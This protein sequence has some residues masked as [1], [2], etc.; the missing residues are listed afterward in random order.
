MKVDH[1]KAKKS[2]T[3]G[4]CHLFGEE[5]REFFN[6]VGEKLID[7][8]KEN[9]RKQ[10]GKEAEMRLL[11]SRYRTIIKFFNPTSLYE[12]VEDFK[13]SLKKELS[14]FFDENLIDKSFD[15]D[16]YRSFNRISL[17]F[18]FDTIKDLQNEILFTLNDKVPNIPRQAL[19]T[20]FK[21][22][23]LYT[24]SQKVTLYSESG[25]CLDQY[26]A[27]DVKYYIEENEDFYL[28]ESI[29][30]KYHALGGVLIRE[31]LRENFVSKIKEFITKDSNYFT[32]WT[33]T[34][35]LNVYCFDSEYDKNLIEI[36]NFLN[37]ENSF[38]TSKQISRSLKNLRPSDLPTELNME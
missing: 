11:N 37:D 16:D 1:I 6:D 8:G 33:L 5:F 24:N 25:L 36:Q 14:L 18:P 7:L 34:D 20:Y 26:N 29:P 4:F 23:K 22:F 32:K 3:D 28:R 12:T 10:Y 31:E 38:K 35:V 27:K 13:S 21:Q 2:L 30:Y 9:G 17:P 19:F 15:D